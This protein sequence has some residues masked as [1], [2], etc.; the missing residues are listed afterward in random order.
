[1]KRMVALIVSAV[2]NVSTLP[3]GASDCGASADE[4]AELRSR[5][6]TVRSRPIKASNKDANCRTYASSFYESVTI[7]QS[8][9]N[10]PRDADTDRKLAAL[11]SEVNTFN[12]LLATRCGT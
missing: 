5:W 11:D 10:C 12:E 4:I 7:R 1:M 9:A 8:A 3:A 6:D 2:M